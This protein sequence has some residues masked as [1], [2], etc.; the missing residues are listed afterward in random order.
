MTLGQISGPNRTTK[1]GVSITPS[2]AFAVQGSFGKMVRSYKLFDLYGEVNAVV[3]PYQSFSSGATA[4]TKD[5]TAF[6]VT[7]GVR[8]KFYPKKKLS[9]FAV[10]GGGAAIYST[11]SKTIAGGTTANS[12]SSASGAL[13]YGGGLE[14]RG[15][16]KMSIRFEARD[17]YTGTPHYGVPVSGKGQFNFLVG[18]GLVFHLGGK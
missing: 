7:P 14:Y 12:G 3:S 4:V 15:S 18:G 17:F 11:S 5:V 1:T 2:N 16:S 13:E 9:P 6:Y 10:V 8:L